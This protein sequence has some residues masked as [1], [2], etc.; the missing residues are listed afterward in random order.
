ML[1]ESDRYRGRRRAPTPPRS[2]YAAVITTAFV[3]AGIVAFGAGAG[4][5]DAKTDELTADVSALSD[6]NARDLAADRANRGER[7]LATSIT[8][9]APDAW[10]LP[11]HNYRL[12]SLFAM[13]WGKMHKG[14][15]LALPEGT[16]Y[17]AVHSGTVIFAGWYGGY[18]YAVI[19]D[20]GQGLQTVYGHSSKLLAKV[21]DQVKAGDVIALVGNTGH[22]FGSHLHLEIHVDGVAVD[23]LPWF[24]KHGVDLKMEIEE[25]YG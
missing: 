17:M 9:T 4:I 14:V 23:P 5:H 15:D 11:G 24:K 21:G 10:V 1:K 12:S 6:A 25:V 22:S 8:S 7:A 3:G 20:H 19:I 16:P 13:R 2:R 18:G